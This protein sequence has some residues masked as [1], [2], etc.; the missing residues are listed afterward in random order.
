MSLRVGFF[1]GNIG[2]EG[3]GRNRNVTDH[4]SVG[5][6]PVLR[7]RVSPFSCVAPSAY[8]PA[9]SD[10]GTTEADGGVEVR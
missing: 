10:P 8:P 1:R 5:K 9:V 2:R 4:E 7:G 3:E 6:T